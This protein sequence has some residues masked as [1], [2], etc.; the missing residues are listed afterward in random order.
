MFVETVLFVGV[1]SRPGHSDVKRKHICEMHEFSARVNFLP[2]SAIRSEAG[3]L[4]S[5][6]RFVGQIANSLGS[7][8]VP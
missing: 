4:V 6:L 3:I 7:T 1:G 5:C 8:D 2:T